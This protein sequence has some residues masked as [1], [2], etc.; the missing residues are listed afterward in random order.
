[1]TFHAKYQDK[2]WGPSLNRV[3]DNKQDNRNKN[4]IVKETSF[5]ISVNY[6]NVIIYLYYELLV[7]Q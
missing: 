6:F 7:D 1:M 4:K 3:G 5:V 2:S